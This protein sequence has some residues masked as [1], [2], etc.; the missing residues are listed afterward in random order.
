MRLLTTIK[1]KLKDESGQA[2]AM[3]LI[4]LV[5]GGLLVVPTLSFM[6]TNLKANRVVDEANLRLYAADAGIQYASSRFLSG[7]DPAAPEFLPPSLTD[8]VNGCEVTLARQFVGD[9]LCVITSTATDPATGKSTEIH[10]SFQAN[11]AQFETAP[12]PFD[13]AVAT[14]GGDLTLTGSSSITS[15]VPGEGNVWVN[16]DIN[17][18]WSCTIDGDA[19]V[20]GTCNRP[21]NIEGTYTPGSDPTDRPEWLDDQVTC[22]IANTDVPTPDFAG[23]AW[24]QVY[25]GNKTLGWSDPYTFD[26]L[27]VTGNLTISG[28]NN[29][30]IYTFNGPSGLKA[31]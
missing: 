3:A 29:G 19:D 20:T 23:Q 15:D 12:S 31:T 21:D 28:T 22:Y 13:Y 10:A 25:S 6:T 7:V 2:L 1:K 16:G 9:D 24:D 14:L 30:G 27:H 18:D 11:A 4:M 8:P 26:S 5:L 17:L